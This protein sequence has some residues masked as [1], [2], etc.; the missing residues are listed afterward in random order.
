VIKLCN[1]KSIYMFPKSFM[2]FCQELHKPDLNLGPQGCHYEKKFHTLDLN[3][4]PMYQIQVFCHWTI[5]ARYLMFPQSCPCQD[6]SWGNTSTKPIKVTR[7]EWQSLVVLNRTNI[8]L[9]GTN[10]S[11]LR[12]ICGILNRG[13]ANSFWN[14]VIQIS[15]RHVF[16]RYI[17]QSVKSKNI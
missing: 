8:F 7:Q 13:M 15:R 3:S 17:F 14:H 9:I 11:F 4:G 1:P 12:F 5:K 16:S 10:I 2:I 6:P